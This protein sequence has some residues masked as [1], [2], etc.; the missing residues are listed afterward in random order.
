M[1]GE[2]QLYYAIIDFFNHNCIISDKIALVQKTLKTINE[3]Y[4][5]I[6]FHNLYKKKI[7][8]KKPNS[9]DKAHTLKETH[10]FPNAF[11]ML[12]YCWKF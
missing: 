10:M 6:L 8:N 11:L 3:K 1:I 9:D 5:F 12:C 7:R 4:F 2:L